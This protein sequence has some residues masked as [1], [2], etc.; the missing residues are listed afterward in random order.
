ED[1]EARVFNEREFHCEYHRK[2]TSHRISSD[3]YDL[4]YKNLPKRHLVLKKVPNCEFCNPKRFPSEGPAFCC[5]KGKNIRHFN[6]HFF[7]TSF[8]AS[9]D[10]RLATTGGTGVYTFKAHG[11]IYHK[12]DQLVPGRKVPR[13]MQLYFYDTDE[14]IS[15]RYAIALNTTVSVDQRRFN[16]PS[17]DQ[18]A[19][20]W[21]HG[22]DSEKRFERSI[23][24]YAKSD[25]A[26]F[27]RP[28]HGCYDPLAY[29]L[30]FPGGETG[31]ES[32][33]ILYRD[34]PVSKPKR[35][36]R[37]RKRQ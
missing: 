36:T 37:K 19:A 33:N 24:I 5:Q 9:I 22:N 13:H 26:V 4:V 18:V 27:I 11:Q 20:I 28:Y 17:M 29:P 6:S 31:W 21:M 32:K 16:A 35:T 7:F 23:V 3:P 14:T 34:P 12:L 30:F 25:H 10:K 15:H 2:P 1:D 8:G